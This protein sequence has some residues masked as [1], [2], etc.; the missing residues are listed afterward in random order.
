MIWGFWNRSLM[1]RLVSHYLLL[2]LSIVALAGTLA[3]FQARYALRSSVID[4]LGVLAAQSEEQLLRWEATQRQDVVFLASLPW[5][6]SLADPLLS[7]SSTVE[8]RALARTG[9]RDLLVSTLALKPYLG[10]ILVL[11]P[12]GGEV[13]L[14]TDGSHLG[15]YRVQDSYFIEGLR[16]TFVQNVYPSPETYL[17]TMTI[18]TPLLGRAEGPLGVLVSHLDLGELDRI[19]EVGEGLGREGEIYLIDSYNAFVSGTRFGRDRFPRGVRSEA[20]ETALAGQDGAGLY[21]NYDGV[22]VIGVFRWIEDL[23]LALV[24]EMPQ[25]EAF[26]PARQLAGLLFGVGLLLA[27]ALNVG[28]YLLSRQ[29]LQPILDLKAAALRVGEGDLEVT[30]PISTDDEIGLLARTFNQM[31]GKLSELYGNLRREIIQRQRTQEELVAKNEELERFTYTVSHDLKSP[32]V[33]ISGFVSFLEKDA[34]AGNHDRVRADADRIRTAADSMARLLDELLK[35]S[36]AGRMVNEPK[37]VPLVDLARQVQDL[38]TGAINARG[39]EVHIAEDLPVVLGDPLRLQ[40][41]VQ[42]LFDNAVK[43][44][45]EETAPQI[46]MGWRTQ[47]GDAVIFVRDNGVGIDPIY[48]E[49]IFSLFERIDDGRK[50]GSGVGL[51]LVKR[52]VEVHGGKIWVESEGMGKGASFCF[53]LPLAEADDDATDVFPSPHRSDGDAAP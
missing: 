39:V 4:R 28:T 3:F 19:L 25:D 9:L 11:S 50:H 52:I 35:L 44:M 15:E 27:L 43:F 36:R 1:A 31:T 46:E 22:P 12:N 47:D 51:A 23:E 2:S 20:I 21:E 26:A 32:L 30:A 41:V 6:V 45:G 40:E 10:E 18:A 38:L 16:G 24:V 37:A 7:S 14:C 33:T 53:T 42:N 49:K 29:I 17:P 5:V 48:H 34:L 8:E 13:V